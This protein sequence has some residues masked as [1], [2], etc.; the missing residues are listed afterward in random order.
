M[1]IEPYDREQRQAQI[2]L[3]SFHATYSRATRFLLV[4]ALRNLRRSNIGTR[5][6]DSTSH[7]RIRSCHNVWQCATL[8]SILDDT[9]GQ[10]TPKQKGAHRRPLSLF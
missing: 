3:W 2:K 9:K 6:G 5:P 10:V 7:Q 1:K 8:K 4:Q